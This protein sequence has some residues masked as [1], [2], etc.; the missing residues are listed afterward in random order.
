M[1]KTKPAPDRQWRRF[2]VDFFFDYS[3]EVIDT[4]VIEIAQEVIDAVDDS[5]RDMLYDLHT[6]EEIAAQV[7]FCRFVLN[8]PLTSMDGWANMN[9]RM[10]RVIKYPTL[11]DFDRV[12]R[13]IPIPSKNEPET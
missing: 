9:D 13:E 10:L 1:S 5:W 11:D 7:G 6:P 8:L 4:G 3:G 12:A 2:E